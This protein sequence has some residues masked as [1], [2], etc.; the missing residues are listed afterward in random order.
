[1]G[2]F[3]RHD[4]PLELFLPVGD[5]LLLPTRLEGREELNGTYEYSIQLVAPAGTPV[6]AEKLLGQQATAKI[7]LPGMAQRFV[8]GIIW[9]LQLCDSDEV[10]DH[11]RISLRPRVAVLALSRRSRV[12]QNISALDIVREVLQPVGGAQIEIR[13]SIPSRVMCVQHRETDLDFVL[14]LCSEEGISHYWRHASL[15]DG[16]TVLVLTDN[17]TEAPSTGRINYDTTV[18][19]SIH[20]T[21]IRSWNLLQTMATV[22]STVADSH[23][24][25]FG[26]RLEASYNAPEAITAGELNLKTTPA[27]G[28]WQMD[29][30]SAARHFDGVGPTGENDSQFAGQIGDAQQRR[31]R[32]AAEGLASALVRADAVG[33]CC[34]VTVG[35]SFHLEDHPTQQGKWLAV[36]VT[37]TVEVKEHY[38]EGESASLL[39]ETRFE[40]APLGLPQPPWPPRPKPVVG[41]IETAVVTGPAETEICMDMYGRAKVRFLFDTRETPDSCWVR[42]AQV[43]AGNSWGAAFWPRVGHEV[44]VAFENGDPDR[45]IITGSVYNSANMPPFELPANA[46]VAG[47]KSLTQGGDPSVN[48]HLILMGDAKG[49]EAVVIHSENILI[50][51]QESQQVAKRPHLD[52]TINEG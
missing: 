47:F 34:H 5:C 45:P 49:E 12:F 4:S 13:N 9:S 22:P 44:V 38:W 11:Y 15:D 36:A 46:Y 52:V 43:W 8:G 41:G 26:Q 3:A 37:L 21:H 25:L 2:I 31:A 6:P 32:I 24:Q 35:H 19:G 18:G 40:A 16:G 7:T 10:L 30:L 50:N 28:F 1:M 23:F 39:C 20:R 48:Y 17:T 14:R 51:Q 33:N 42:V 27:S 29:A